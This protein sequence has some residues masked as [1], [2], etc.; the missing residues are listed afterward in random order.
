MKVINHLFAASHVFLGAIGCSTSSSETTDAVAVASASLD[1][2]KYLLTEEP[3]G[4][5][6]VIEARETAKDGYPIVIV[7]RIGGA[8]NPWIEGRAAFMLLDAS[9]VMVANGADS[10]E[11]ELC[12]DDCCAADR[13][14]CTTLVKVV[15]ANGKLI[16]ADARK[17]LGLTTEDMVVVRG[18]ANVDEGEN[19]T[20]LADAVHIRR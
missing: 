15:D 18:T 9:K 10:G 16:A 5:V 17:L 2:S 14:G 12:M 4:A 19:F 7:G 8:D 1:G 3:E 6:G 11:E 20:V 13:A